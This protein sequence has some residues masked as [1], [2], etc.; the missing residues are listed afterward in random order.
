MFQKNS[1]YLVAT[2]SAA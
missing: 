2:L 1:D